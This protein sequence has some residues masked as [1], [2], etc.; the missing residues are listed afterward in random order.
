MDLYFSRYGAAS[1]R[2]SPVNR[3]MSSF[4]RDFRDGIDINLGVGYVNEKTIPIP[5]LREA[6]DAV[7]ADPVRYRQAFNYG[8]AEGSPNLIASIRR[9]LSA[10]RIGGLDEETLQRKR[11]IIGT[12]GASSVLDS[13][14][15]VFQPGIVVTSDP[16]YYVFCDALERKGFEV[17][18]IPEDAEGMELEA[19]DRGLKALGNRVSEIAFFYVV[20]VNNPSGTILSNAR[21]RALVEVAVKLSVEQGRRIP[22]FFD[23]AYQLLVHD[24][25]AERFE[26]AL[27][28]DRMEIVYEIGTLSKVLAPALR[29]G[30]LLGPGGDLMNAMVQKTSDSGFSASLLAQE[31][32]SYLLDNCMK[33]QLERVRAGYREKALRIRRRIEEALSPYLEECRGGS[34]GFYFYLTFREVETHAS[35]PFFHYLT[36]STGEADVDGAAEDPLPRVYYVPG[37]H[38]VHPRGAMVEVGRRQLRLSYGYEDVK[39]ILEATEWM[40]KAAEYAQ[41]SKQRV[42]GSISALRA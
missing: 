38:C 10:H 14:S 16:N 7:I 18:A 35:S 24:P 37:E 36:R 40:R 32:A 25:E 8:G 13:L 11:L 3:M 9:F 2:P 6:L 22:I 1:T 42:G 26:S 17:L 28:G 20:T 27:P 33:E 23:E 4:A 34:A 21:R 29:V 5:R 30:Y 39:A 41:E 31:M 12:C 19:L 15:E